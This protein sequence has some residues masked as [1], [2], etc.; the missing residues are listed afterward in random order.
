LEIASR[1][2]HL[3]GLVLVNLVTNA[4]EASP[5]GSVVR[6]EVAADGPRVAFSVSDSGPGL[7]EPV[8]AGLFRP[9]RSAKRGGGG[10]G[11]AIS[12]RLA[13][14]AGG[15][16]ELVASGDGG[17]TFRVWVPRATS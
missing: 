6:L 11:L 7:P 2:A 13:R 3:A 12:H 10:V 4:I 16:L 14:H 8:R 5:R 1:T 17:T 15:T 9:V